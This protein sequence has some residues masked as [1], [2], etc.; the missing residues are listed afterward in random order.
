MGDAE[1]NLVYVSV[2]Q[3]WNRSLIARHDIRGNG[4]LWIYGEVGMEAIR[5]Q[6]SADDT[7]EAQLET[8]IPLELTGY[9]SSVAVN[10]VKI[11]RCR[12]DPSRVDFTH[13]GGMH[14]GATRS[15]A[16]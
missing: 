12:Q 3:C 14:T 13:T 5:L 1:Y 6:M 4:F 8:A 9:A 11:L 16:F 10:G 7:K 2:S 15:I